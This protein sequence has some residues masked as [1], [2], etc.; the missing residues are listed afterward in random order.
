M[1]KISPP[2]GIR[3]PDLPARSES[4]RLLQSVGV[5]HLDTF[6][7]T[8]PVLGNRSGKAM[9]RCQEVEAPWVDEHRHMKMVRLPALRTGLLYPQEIFLVLISVR[10]ARGGAVVEALRYKPEGRGIDSGWCHWNFLSGT[11]TLTHG[12]LQTDSA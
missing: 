3:S 9:W 8:L 6:Q 12:Q 1:R 7:A 4:Y 2:T 5:P 11:G 10:G